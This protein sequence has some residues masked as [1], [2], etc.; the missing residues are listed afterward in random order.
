MKAQTVG[1][2]LSQKIILIIGVTVPFVAFIGGIIHFWGWGVNGFYLALFA[3]FYTFTLLGI[4]IGNHRLFTH[5]SYKAT[6]F[7]KYVAG[8][9]SGMAVEGSLFKWCAKHREHHKESDKKS[10]PH[11]PHHHGDGVKGMLKG[12]WHAHVGWMYSDIDTDREKFIPDLL[13]DKS[14]QVIDRLQLVWIILGFVLPASIGWIVTESF[15]GALLGCL[16]GGLIRIFILHHVTWSINSIC[17]YFGYRSFET[18]DMSTNNPTLAPISGGESWHNN[19]HAFP[20]SAR[21]GL[22]WWEIDWSW[23]VIR[24]LEKLHLVTDVR[25]PSKE[26]MDALRIR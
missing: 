12:L 26:Q 2:P 6:T 19:H 24:G 14:L 25:I 20:W 16:W 21:H 23:Y 11:S 22:R 8:I 18:N 9:W 10:D 3:V 1:A 15:T 7:I 5:S 4:S 17:H 13:K